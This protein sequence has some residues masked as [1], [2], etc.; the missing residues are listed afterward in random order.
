MNKI[1]WGNNRKMAA[2]R[3]ARG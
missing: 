3:L 2:A 1:V